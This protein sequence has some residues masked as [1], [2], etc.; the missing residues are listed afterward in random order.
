MSKI[1]RGKYIGERVEK[2]AKDESEHFMK[3][4]LC[5]GM[6][7]MRDLGQVFDHEGRLPHPSQDQKQ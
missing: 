7:D 3:C 1:P 4:E 5:G 2:P 6:F